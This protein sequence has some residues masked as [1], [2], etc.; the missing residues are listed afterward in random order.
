MYVTDL[1]EPM[2]AL[3]FAFSMNEENLHADRVQQDVLVLASREDHFIP[4]RLHEAG[5]QRL[6]A[7]RSLTSRVFTRQEHAQNHCQIGNM[8]LAL[9]VMKEWIE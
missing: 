9:D 6:T 4:F 5:L 7:A 3:D 2:A 8:G 1:D